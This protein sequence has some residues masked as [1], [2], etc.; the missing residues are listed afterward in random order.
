M[1][2]I[3]DIYK[4]TPDYIISVIK[5]V[6]TRLVW[7]VFRYCCWKGCKRG[8]WWSLT[9]G[10]S[11]SVSRSRDFHWDGE[12]VTG[13][14]VALKVAVPWPQ[15]LHGAFGSSSTW[16]GFPQ[17]ACWEWLILRSHSVTST[18]LY[19]L[20]WTHVCL[21]S[22]GKKLRPHIFMKGGSKVLWQFL[23]TTINCRHNLS[24]LL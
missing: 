15:V 11:S 5:W 9:R 23:K 2:W 16:S 3:P 13:T 7:I 8:R 6:L 21:D 22:R 17:E 1:S 18:V 12:V 4:Q 14:A 24:I 20:K 19:W 10:K